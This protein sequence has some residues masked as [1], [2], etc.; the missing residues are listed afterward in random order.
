METPVKYWWGRRF[1]MLSLSPFHTYTWSWQ[2]HRNCWLP[3]ASRIYLQ[4]HPYQN[5]LIMNIFCA[6]LRVS[7]SQKVLFSV[8][9]LLLLH[10]MYLVKFLLEILNIFLKFV[11]D[12]FFFFL[13]H[14]ITNNRHLHH[15]PSTPSPSLSLS[16]S[17]SLYIYIIG[18]SN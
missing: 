7:K 2:T 4:K 17:L 14:S 11:C 9:I 13:V 15:P 1:M 6:Y 8:V 12:F 16:L 3:C 5:I 18:C 10:P